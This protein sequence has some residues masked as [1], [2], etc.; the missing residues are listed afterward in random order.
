M[1]LIYNIHKGNITMTKEEKDSIL[2]K[3]IV[4]AIILAIFIFTPFVIYYGG[5]Y[6]I[7]LLLTGTMG[8]V[9]TIKQ[10]TGKK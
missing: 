9:S 2:A 5:I 1:E 10:L 4:A 7:I 6:L 8:I 3:I